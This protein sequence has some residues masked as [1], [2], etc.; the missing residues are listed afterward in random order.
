MLHLWDSNAYLVSQVF[1]E[2][3]D[4]RDLIWQICRER[5]TM[6]NMGQMHGLNAWASKGPVMSG[7]VLGYVVQLSS[8]Q[9]S[10]KKD[11]RSWVSAKH[12][13]WSRSPWWV[14]SEF[15]LSILCLGLNLC[16]QHML[17]RNSHQLLEHVNKVSRRPT[18]HRSIQECQ[19]PFCK[20]RLSPVA[21][22]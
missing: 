15:V 8:E 10:A 19:T 16:C 5:K 21:G 18:K 7:L 6:P 9:R 12:C 20:S 13:S 22:A 11:Q 14:G 17:P 2:V 1:L 4:Q 3:R